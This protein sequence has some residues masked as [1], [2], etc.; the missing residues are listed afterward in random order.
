MEH[1]VS[2]NLVLLA[3][4]LAKFK[5]VKCMLKP[6]YY[7]YKKSIEE[8]RKENFKKHGRQLLADFDKAFNENGIPYTLAFGSILGAVRE[9]GFIKHD[10]DIDVFVWSDDF[11]DIIK[12]VLVN[13]GFA[14]D[15]RFLV[16]DGKLCREE[17][18]S[19][20][21]IAID[22][23][24]LYNSEDGLVYT[25]DYFPWDGYVTWENS[26][27]K[28][29]KILARRIEIPVSK[30]RIQVDFEGIK[31]YIPENYD[32]FLKFRYGEDYMTPK[33]GWTNGKNPHIF[34]WPTVKATYTNYTK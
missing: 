16:E 20:Y 11:S 3:N 18:Y 13:N 23:F 4:R 12:T 15:H 26:M 22:I 1:S 27:D 19:K 6:F 21:G 10:F 9:H 29:G 33:P 25:C 5:V 24:Y 28:L 32:E 8:S 2:P 31:A 14:L 7:R 17:T 34:E 30:T